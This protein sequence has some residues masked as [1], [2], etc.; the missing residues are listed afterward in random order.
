MLANGV[1]DSE[2][3]AAVRSFVAFLQKRLGEDEDE[4]MDELVQAVV[5]QMETKVAE[6]RGANVREA[7]LRQSLDREI[8]QRLQ[9]EEAHTALEQQLA[10]EMKAVRTDAETRRRDEAERSNSRIAALQAKLEKAEGEGASLTLHQELEQE[11]VKQKRLKT[12]ILQ[13]QRRCEEVSGQLRRRDKEVKE[14]ESKLLARV[15]ELDEARRE[16]KLCRKQEERAEA[17]GSEMKAQMEDWRLQVEQ[18]QRQ[19]RQLQKEL[20]RMRT[21]HAKG[22]ANHQRSLEETKSH[23]E[24][25]LARCEQLQQ[26]VE[27]SNDRH[28]TQVEGMQRRHEHDLMDAGEELKD[29][30]TRER[31]ATADADTG[32]RAADEERE[33]LQK[34]LELQGRENEEAVATLEAA[35]AATKRRAVEQEEQLVAEISLE[36]E[37]RIKA[38]GMIRSFEEQ[39]REQAV[40]QQQTSEDRLATRQAEATAALESLVKTEATMQ[41]A[42][43]GAS[44][45]MS[46]ALDKQLEKLTGQVTDKQRE[47][48][49][50]QLAALRKACVN[51]GI[52]TMQTEHPNTIADRLGRRDLHPDLLAADGATPTK[53]T[54]GSADGVTANTALNGESADDSSGDAIL[55]WQRRQQKLQAEQRQELKSEVVKVKIIAPVMSAL[56]AVEDDFV[57]RCATLRR[58]LD[59]MATAKTNRSEAASGL[60]VQVVSAQVRCCVCVCVCVVCVCSVFVVCL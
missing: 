28:R 49:E 8:Q 47:V 29:T 38:E 60:S 44:A 54:A 50:P 16:L 51:S 32:K 30:K 57:R 52:E 3:A 31:K 20:Q 39:S 7:Q 24:E 10:D 56:R 25:L 37:A 5:G 23:V 19:A 59:L 13:E 1:D 55:V 2:P 17:D 11:E 41:Q 48:L 45:V 14:L 21:E 4:E 15:G 27:S 58:D 35:L 36:R 12:E 53:S 40:K 26:Q 42:L 9:M 18:R 33:M 43:N 22:E 34:R 6:L 46:R